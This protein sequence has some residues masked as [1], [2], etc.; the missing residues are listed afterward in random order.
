VFVELHAR[1]AFSFLEGAALPEALAERAAALEQ[2][3]LALLD[4]DGLYGA[5]RFYRAATRVGINPLVGAEVTLAEGGRLPLLVESPEGYQNLCRLITK[6]KMFG[7]PQPKARRADMEMVA[8]RSEAAV[9]LDQVAEHAAGLVCLTGSGDGPLALSLETGGADAARARLDRLVGLF[10]RGNV[11]V[12]L[13]R[14]L[15]RAEET[16]NEWLRGEAARSGLPL[17][18]TNAPR[19]AERGQRPLLDALTCIRH[20]TTLD[21]AGR[22]LADNSERHLRPTREM[23][24]L[25][26]DCP[27]AVA[28][29]GELAI[30]LAFTLKHLGYRFPDYPLPPGQTPIGFLRHLAE[31]GRRVRYARDRALAERARKQIARELDLIARLDLAGYFLIVWDLVEYCRREN[32]LVQGRGSAANS[33]VC[34]ALGITAVDPVGMELLFERFLSE[35]RGE[36][37]DIDLDLPSGDRRE[38]VIQYVYERYGRLGAAMTANVITYRGRLAAREVGKALGLPPDLIERLSRFVSEFEYKDPGDT[39]LTHLP[40]A[41]CDPAHP[42][43]Q[44]FAELWTAIQDLPRHLGQHSGGMVIC[45]GRLDGVVPLEPASM[46]GRSVVQWDKDDCGALG[47]VKVDLLGLGMMSLLQDAIE[48]LAARG[49]IVDLAQLPADDPTVYAMLQQADTVG[50]FQV[51]S[52]AQM[53]TLPRLRPERFYD[54]VVQVAIIRPGPIVGDMVHPYLRRRAGR[55][56]VTVPHPSLEPILRRTLG[57]PLFQEQLL[58]MAMAT[59]GFTGGEAEE[60]RRALGFKRSVRAMGEIEA[61]LRAGMARQGITGEP[62]EAII[63]SIT[64]FAL[65]GFPE[66]VVGDTR[67]I[68]ADTGRRVKIEDV[69]TGRASLAHTLACGEDLRLHKRR[70]LAATSSGPRMVYRLRTALGREVTATAEHPLL[71]LDGWC[72]LGHLRVGDQI[73]AP[74]TLP[75]LGERR[76]PR[77]ELVVLADL[78]AEGNLCHPSTPYFYTTDAQHR[79]EFIA[80]V[81]KFDNTQATVALHRS[82]FSVHTRRRELSRPNGVVEWAKRLGLWGVNAHAKRLPEEVFALHDEDLA[83]LLA[84]LWEGDGTLSRA[85]HASY[86]TASRQLAKEVQHLLLRLGIVA[87]IYERIRP[88]RDRQVTSFIVT[89]TGDDNLQEFNRLIVRQFLSERKRSLANV[90]TRPGM[91]KCSSRDVIPVAIHEI[92]NGSRVRAGMTWNE[93]QERT[94]LSPRAL[95]SPDQSKRGYRR[96]VVARLGECFESPVLRCLASS[97]VYWDSV[98]AIEAVGIQE[99]YDLSVEGDHNFIANDLIVHNSHAASFALLAYASTF[100]KAH[101]PA[102]FYAAL[103]NNQPMGFYHPATIVRDAQRHGQALRPIDVTRSGWLCAIEDDGSVRL[104]LRYVKGLREEIGKRIEAARAERPFDSVADLV[105][106]SGVN[107]EELARL[108]EVGA[109]RGLGLERRQALWEGERAIRPTGPLYAALPDPPSPSPLRRMTMDERVVADYEGTDLSIGPHPLALRRRGLAAAGVVRAADLVGL[110]GGSA[111]R[112]AGAVVVR[113]RPGTAK[114]FVFLNLEDETGLINVIVRPQFFA[115]YRVLLTAEPFLLVAGTLQHEDRVISVR[116]DR[117]WRL[118]MQMGAVPSH[119]FH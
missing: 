113:Q 118:D 30:R 10:G 88:Y 11:F 5:P 23:E 49:S 28:N 67:V 59:A 117:L 104:G 56:P 42:R 46:P 7:E 77:H 17:L 74:R 25:F 34:Y 14:R 69:V 103:L 96:W 40:A 38:R 70:V 26:A 116:A 90:L 50:V 114:G 95:C 82:C 37:P 65:Y 3:A 89:V 52:R 51:E 111:V 100:M 61:K 39:L 48:M 4:R 41:G 64:A 66:C 57:V 12:E 115:R 79:D 60:L 107:R 9:T 6:M 75:G 31:A 63:R 78:I 84:R 22:L 99:T 32:I 106:R 76:W 98:V 110:P 44:R 94:G 62:A 97:D 21:R 87:R 1:S 29:S 85:R 2:P 47:I 68:D 18:A 24:R 109:L 73:A 80:A 101:H 81:E 8:S 36:W 119:D 83:I 92:I 35:E 112:V 54:L 105:Q 15:H 13:Q 86:D 43:I 71:T 93:I 27:E 20:H 108:G 16:R 102:A 33:A 58:R 55:E 91:S 53:A 72:P 45:Q 19:L